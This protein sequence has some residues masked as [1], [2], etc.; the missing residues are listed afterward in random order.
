MFREVTDNEQKEEGRMKTS[1]AF[2]II[3]KDVFLYD[4]MI[5]RLLANEYVS[6]MSL[7]LRPHDVLFSFLSLSFHFYSLLRYDVTK[8]GKVLAHRLVFYIYFSSNKDTTSNTPT[9]FFQ[10]HCYRYLY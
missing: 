1:D 5:S 8:E 7:G 10:A 2:D 3:E 4:R 6:E 9:I